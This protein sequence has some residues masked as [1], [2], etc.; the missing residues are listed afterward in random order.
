MAIE[1]L[2]LLQEY[3]QL[4][5]ILERKPVCVRFP[6]DIAMA[7]SQDVIE[8]LPHPDT[9]VEEFRNRIAKYVGH[10]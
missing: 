1:S 10:Y 8:D 5:L 4:D 6:I 7:G 9:V 3:F 2:G